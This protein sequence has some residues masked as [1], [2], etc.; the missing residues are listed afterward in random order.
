M[1]NSE[2]SNRSKS[3]ILFHKNLSP[4]DLYKMALI[5]F[6]CPFKTCGTQSSVSGT[7]HTSACPN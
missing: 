3:Q 6:V 5:P 1:K 7:I 4:S 2:L